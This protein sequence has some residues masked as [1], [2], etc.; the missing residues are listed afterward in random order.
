[1]GWRFR[2]PAA[3]VVAQS[4]FGWA[5][6]LLAFA[7]VG[8]A[9]AAAAVGLWAL[10]TTLTSVYV[11]LGHPKEADAVVIRA[12]SY[13]ASMIAWLRTGVVP[14]THAAATLGRHTREAIWYTAAA[15][16]TANLASIAM[17][18]VL[19]NYM[20]AY[21]ATLLRARR[22]TGR[23][24]LLA[25]N[26]WSLVRVAAYVMIGAS[27]SAPLLRF[28]GWRVNGP[29]VTVL[30][31]GGGAGLLLDAVLKLGLSQ[32]WGRALAEAVDLEAAAANRSSE[33]PLT[34]HLD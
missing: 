34:L 8:A 22:R 14:E 23:V 24:L 29:A 2:R 17:G 1:V 31:V 15:M 13:R 28:A 5:A 30:A 20:N 10:G 4:L 7:L 26:V 27:A 33:A 18:A 11:F 19:L 25:W 32:R 21:V 9:W 3:L 12:A 6:F 16:A